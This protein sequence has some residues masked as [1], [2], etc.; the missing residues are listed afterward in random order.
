MKEQLTPIDMVNMS[1]TNKCI[2][3][4]PSCPTGRF[5]W[6]RKVDGKAA[7][8]LQYISLDRCQKIFAKVANLYGPQLF[9]LHIWNEPLIHPQINEILTALHEFEHTA[10]ISSNLNVRIDWARL[11]KSPALKTLVIS[12]S[13]FTQ[14]VYER[15]HR[16]GNV[17]LVLENIKEISK[18]TKKNKSSTRVLINFHRYIDN[19][20]DSVQ[21][22]EL[23]KDSGIEFCPYPA[24]V[25]QENIHTSLSKG[26]FE[27]WRQS[28]D[29]TR[30]VLPRISMT[31]FP[32]APISGLETIPC[33]SQS[34]ILVLDHEGQICTCTHKEP[35]S[36]D[37]LGD[38]L[39]MDEDA[40]QN[41]KSNWQGCEKCRTLGL[42][43][44]YVFACF[45]EK[46]SVTEQQIMDFLAESEPH[47]GYAQ[48][49]IFIFGAGMTGA[50]VAPLL[51]HHGYNILSFI[52]DNPHKVGKTL[53]GI[54]IHS[55]KEVASS[56]EKALV[57]DTVR[58]LPFKSKALG[59]GIRY[60]N[61]TSAEEFIAK[62]MREV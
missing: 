24:V 59:L 5:N 11:L 46:P 10:Y 52:D 56:L 29:I 40:I 33:H 21:L 22:E 23:C 62:L 37:R 35:A 30:L 12:M 32:F 58:S 18:Y 47:S 57:I 1:I 55:L 3:A 60:Q 43:M 13:G 6:Q 16:G 36:V 51:R 44:A 53:H 25:L 49:E 4:C 2:L 45:F 26:L 19:M 42:H 54:P 41:I 39:S 38:F 48:Q 14:E 34:H 20:D 61:T 27:T 17:R 31:P 9:Y 50:A 8:P 15:G 28:D 7:L